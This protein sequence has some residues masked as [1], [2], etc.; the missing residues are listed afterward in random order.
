MFLFITQNNNKINYQHTGFNELDNIKSTVYQ[1]KINDNDND[2]DNDII[3]KL[4]RR[5]N[6]IIVIF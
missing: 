6:F 5:H 4:I 2:N 3:I 1:F